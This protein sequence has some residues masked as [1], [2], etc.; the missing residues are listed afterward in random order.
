MLK[1]NEK[2]HKILLENYTNNV[3]YTPK[4]RY[5]LK[6]LANGWLVGPRYCDSE[7]SLIATDFEDAL[8]KLKQLHKDGK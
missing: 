8:I 6:E 7:D 4:K 2:L 5:E 1:F 3:P